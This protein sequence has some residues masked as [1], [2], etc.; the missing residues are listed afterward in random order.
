MAVTTN[1]F[2]SGN[3]DFSVSGAMRSFAA[4][5]HDTNYLVDPDIADRPI[6][7]R[8]ISMSAEGALKVEYPRGTIDTIPAGH[9]AA[10]VIHPMHVCRVF[11]TGT[12]AQTVHVWL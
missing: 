10:G 2:T 12:G 5:K 1:D 7:S 6:L 11:D 3:T 8:G 9:L 4:V